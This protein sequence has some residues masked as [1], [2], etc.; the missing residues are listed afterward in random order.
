MKLSD[1]LKY[2]EIVIQCHD[3][4][5]ADT[6]A[7]GFGLYQYYVNHGKKVRFIY[8]GQS[9]I[10]KKNLLIMV[11]ELQIPIEYV[12]ELEVPELLL[13][14]DCQYGEGNVT[15]FIANQV[16]MIDHH[17]VCVE[18]NQF[19]EIRSNYG[20]CA[21]VVYTMLIEE[22]F[23]ISSNM[24]LSTALYYGLYMDTNGF[25]EMKHPFDLDMMEDAHILEYLISKLK[26][27]NFS[28]EEIV[29]AGA[30]MQNY[31]YIK[32]ERYAIVKTEPCDPNI[33]G[34]ISDMILQVDTIDACV[35]YSKLEYG[36]KLS[37]RSCRRDVTANDLAHYLTEKMGNGG[38]HK[39]KAGGFIVA[40]KFK[41]ANPSC[42]FKDY[43]KC[44]M[45]Q[46]FN[47]YD[48]V[49]T[50]IDIVNNDGM[51]IYRKLPV[52]IGFAKTLDF[53]PAGTIL[54]ARTLE[55][56][57]TI[58]ADPN[59]YVMIGIEG[60]VYPV[61]KKTFESSYLVS[62]VPYLIKTEYIPTVRNKRT[63]EVYSLC[64]FA[65]TCVSLGESFILAKQINKT[66]KVFTKW[67][68]DDYMLGVPGDYLAIRDD[69]RNDAYIIKEKIMEKTYELR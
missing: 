2:N 55:G 6:I 11:K 59:I 61:K 1:L 67:Y 16:A 64:D 41:E 47:S 39:K 65:R 31:E 46:Y 69:G 20:S 37:V 60:E 49:D 7:S 18:E 43:I 40:N 21:T 42:D 28:A 34:F 30:A 29:L 19:T 36:Y 32:D 44:R 53:A 57:V 15:N 38:G 10:Q 62:A 56:D 22:G 58:T 54:V 8:S 9:S 48:I 26:N 52:T 13:L 45:T 66:T 33:L 63:E 35:V 24:K 4:P 68:Y 5:D 17:E 27:S 23:P 14:T 51:K 12:T 3:N 50:T 25:G